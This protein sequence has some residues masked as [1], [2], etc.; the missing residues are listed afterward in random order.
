MKFSSRQRKLRCEFQLSTSSDK[1]IRVAKDH[2]KK[3][4]LKLAA[5][6]S[7]T[8][9]SMSVHSHCVRCQLFHG[10]SDNPNEFLSLSTFTYLNNKVCPDYGGVA[11]YKQ[12]SSKERNRKYFLRAPEKFVGILEIFLK[13]YNF[14]EF[15]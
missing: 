11:L 4:R 8:V 10:S 1:T 14:K 12:C 9:H 3:F 15:H 5:S 13:F 7:V 2:G 6:L